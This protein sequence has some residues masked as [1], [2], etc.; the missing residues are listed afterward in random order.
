MLLKFCLFRTGFRGFYYG[1]CAELKC[2]GFRGKQSLCPFCNSLSNRIETTE[3]CTGMQGRVQRRCYGSVAGSVQRSPRYSTL[4][5][6]DVRHFEEILGKK[7]VIQ[8]EERLDAANTDW[9]QKYKG[10]S[11]LLLLP[12]ST[13]EVPILLFLSNN[14]CSEPFGS[15]IP[16]SYIQFI[17]VLGVFLD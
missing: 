10:S 9:M 7:N 8:D 13:E 6:E 1:S 3:G 16:F 5:D 17:V 4:N 14:F 15:C 11:K 2:N 12:R